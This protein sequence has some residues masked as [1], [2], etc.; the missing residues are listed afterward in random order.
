LLN[1]IK[2][3]KSFQETL[4][5]LTKYNSVYIRNPDGPSF[6][7]SSLGRFLGPT[8]E[9]KKQDGGDHSKAGKTNPDASLDRFIVKKIFYSCQNGLGLTI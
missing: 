8:F 4:K 3:G 1:I 5:K 6:E 9:W 2:T 7:W